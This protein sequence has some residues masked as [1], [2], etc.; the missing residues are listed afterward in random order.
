MAIYKNAL[1]I[2]KDGMVLC[3]DGA[4]QQSV[5]ATPTI[6]Y[7]V[8]S[9]SIGG[10]ALQNG[11]VS[12]NTTTA[13]DGTL[14][15]DLY[16][17]NTGNTQHRGFITVTI[18]SPFTFSIYAKPA[19]YNFLSLGFS[20]GVNGGDII[21]NLSAGT[22]SG[23]S[24]GFI[25]YIESV[26][27]G[28]Y[29]CGITHTLPFELIQLSYL[30]IVRN[31]NT[32]NNY[33]G[34][35]ISGM[36]LWGA[37]LEL[38]TKITP[39]IKALGSVGVRD[40][41]WVD[42]VNRQPLTLSGW[43]NSTNSSS[44]NFN[45]N[46]GFGQL[47]SLV[48]LP[49]W[50]V[51]RVYRNN[52]QANGLVVGSK[53]DDVYFRT[54]TNVEVLTRI[55]STF[56]IISK[57]CIDPSD[58]IFIGSF[59]LYKYQDVTKFLV[60]KLNSDGSI[61]TN[62]ELTGFN[63]AA[64]M[65]SSVN[66]TNIIFSSGG[67]IGY[68]GSSNNLTSQTIFNPNTGERLVNDIPGINV[69]GGDCLWLDEPNNYLYVTVS[70]TT[71]I[72]GVAYGGLVRLNATTLVADSTFD[73]TNG[74]NGVVRNAA[75][76]TINNKLY[77]VGAFTSYKGQT[78]NRII[79]LNLDGSIDN[80]FVVGTGFNGETNRIFL[81]SSNKPIVMGN[82]TSYSGATRNYITRLNTDG[83]IDNTFNI[84]TGFNFRATDMVYDRQ[85][86]KIILCG[87]FTT[88]NGVSRNR[89]VRLN[90][91]GSL[92]TSFVI[93]TGLSNQ[94]DAVALQSD[95]KIIVGMS[96]PINTLRTFTHTY[97]GTQFASLIRL[98]SDGSVDPTFN[99]GLGFTEGTYR[100]ELGIRYFTSGGTPQ[101]NTLFTLY[102]GSGG[103]LPMSYHQNYYNN[104]FHYSVI[105]KGDD[106]IYRAYEDGILR[107]TLTVPSGSDTRL[108]FQRISGMDDVGAIQIYNRALT[109]EE[110]IQNYN[111][112]K[113]RFNLP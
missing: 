88:Y 42:L 85:N 24:S 98:N 102:P 10:W 76:D 54:N 97:N 5:P 51:C 62:F 27:D 23:V 39:Y 13:P 64:N 55:L 61:N 63:N 20:G 89:I 1:P 77:C 22:V 47:P 21:F 86:D 29:R 6:N 19:G 74:F 45:N 90:I 33:S 30:F 8:P 73:T 96:F 37:Q 56:G 112:M 46:R 106:N 93:G 9:E 48:S 81:D 32:I 53:L 108:D 83:S 4:S 70:T 59:G 16:I 66:V 40:N 113:L 7:A 31:N 12:G 110:V 38:G 11:T 36:F 82:F 78:Y 50:S 100:N 91:D 52:V 26:G 99:T 18:T 105:T 75:L 104:K 71:V 58:N 34:D 80:T 49:N 35:G 17:P 60:V 67:T 109:Q 95:G 25:P 94:A 28:W 84:G 65:G 111:S 79:R 68:V 72:S 57:I 107:N 69:V 43:T 101:I 44:F 14:T 103:R 92:D 15:A 41:N 87:V 2:V 3:L